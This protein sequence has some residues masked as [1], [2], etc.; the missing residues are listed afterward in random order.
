M[1]MSKNLGAYSDIIGVLAAAIAAGGATFRLKTHGKARHW[2]QR[3][4]YLR[5]L[6]HEKQGYSE[7]DGM[8]LTIKEAQVTIEFDVIEGVLKDKE[9]K[10]IEATAQ[11]IE[12]KISEEDYEM[13]EGVRKD[14]GL[15]VG[16]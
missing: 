10:V 14:L 16:G 1:S 5:R 13:M 15:E 12:A 2:A 9:G 3:A 11:R 8:K 7:Y 6:L 4:Y